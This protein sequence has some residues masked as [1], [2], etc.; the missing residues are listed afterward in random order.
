MKYQETVRTPSPRSA[1]RASKSEELRSAA[2]VVSVLLFRGMRERRRT[3]GRGRAA[4]AL[5]A[6]LPVGD[7]VVGRVRDAYVLVAVAA[8]SVDVRGDGDDVVG[9]D[10]GVPAGTEADVVPGTLRR[11]V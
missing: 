8:A 4:H 2:H 10:V 5:V 9:V 3:N 11:R 6:R 7:N 1:P